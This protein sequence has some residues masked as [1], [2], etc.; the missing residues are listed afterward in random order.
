M[1]LTF[2]AN[3]TTYQLPDDKEEAHKIFLDQLNNRGEVF[4]IAYGFTEPGM[5]DELLAAHAA[6]IP[7][8]IYL[9]HT[10]SAGR[11]ERVQVKRLVEAGMDVTIG[12]STE[13]S[14][15]IC[16]TK[17][18]V[19][20]EDPA[21]PFCWTGSVNFS[22]SGWHQENYVTTFSSLEWAQSFIANFE[23]MKAFAWAHEAKFQLLAAEQEPK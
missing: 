13:G 10:Q 18:F 12:T 22:E 15:Y 14:A 11:T 5:I 23:K 19:V 8:H 2:L 20:L 9:D 4:L 21:N 17:G 1:S 3:I 16:H 7:V 6:G